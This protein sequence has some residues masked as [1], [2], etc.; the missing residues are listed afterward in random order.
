MD[1][2]SLSLTQHFDDTVVSAFMR[3]HHTSLGSND[4]GI[5]H[6][7]GGHIDR[8]EISQ[9]FPVACIGHERGNTGPK[10]RL[11][12]RDVDG[13]WCDRSRGLFSL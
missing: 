12:C 5:A 6:A 13:V 1:G 7:E 2:F 4:L 8:N 11:L 9:V 10:R 3:S